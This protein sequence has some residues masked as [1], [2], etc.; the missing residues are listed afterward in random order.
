MVGLEAAAPFEGLDSSYHT[1]V[2]VSPGL[3]ISSHTLFSH[4]RAR[5]VFQTRVFRTMSSILTAHGK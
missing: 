5:K 1:T 4:E 2:Q 3:G